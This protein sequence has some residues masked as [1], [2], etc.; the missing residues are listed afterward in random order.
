MNLEIDKTISLLTDKMK[1]L[2]QTNVDEYKRSIEMMLFK[3]EDNLKE[4]SDL[5]WNEIK[6]NSFFFDRKFKLKDELKQISV[7][8]V[9]NA[10]KSIFIKNPKKLSIQVT[11]Q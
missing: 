2:T 1:N 3:P 5:Y 6:E 11:F 10:Y 9:K 7:I 4:R 8:D